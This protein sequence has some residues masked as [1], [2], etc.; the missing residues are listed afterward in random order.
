VRREAQAK[1]RSR[2]QEIKL[3]DWENRCGQW[4][5]TVF[6]WE[7]CEVQQRDSALFNSRAV[8]PIIETGL[9]VF[10]HISALLSSSNSA[11]RVGL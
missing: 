6:A 5:F 8:F 2:K 11:A 3:S 9:G 7:C 1:P 10:S 4:C